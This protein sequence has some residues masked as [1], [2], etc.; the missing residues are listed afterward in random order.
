MENG[1]ARN[2]SRPS[3]SE[4]PRYLSR[5]ITYT[6]KRLA[7][8][9]GTFTSGKK[10]IANSPPISS[11]F[12]YLFSLSFSLLLL[13]LLLLL[14]FRDYTTTITSTQNSKFDFKKKFADLKLHGNL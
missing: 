2:K 8:K 14:L 13:L 5:L 11:L 12:Q 6:S 1:I 10:K 4:F 3:R 7:L 9:S